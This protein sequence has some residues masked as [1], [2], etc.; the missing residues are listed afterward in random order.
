[1]GSLSRCLC[2]SKMCKN[3][4]DYIGIGVVFYANRIVVKTSLVG[5][6]NECGLKKRY[7]HIKVN[8]SH[9][10]VVTPKLPLF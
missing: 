7:E 9:C 2:K 8:G 4:K 1:M 3:V 5:L 6:V 10:S